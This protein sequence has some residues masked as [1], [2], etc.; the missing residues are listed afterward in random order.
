MGLNTR[1]GASSNKT[2]L[3]V[4]QGNLVL[5]Y[6]K[7]AD[8][9]KKVESLGLDPDKIQVRQRTKGKNEGKDVFYYVLY[10]VSGYLTSITLNE[11]S[12]GEFLELEFTDVDEKFS[13][14]LGD[15]YSRMAKDFIRRVGGL[16]LNEEIVFSVWNITAEEADNGKSKSGVLMYQNDEKVEYFVEFEDLP[17]PEQ[18]KKGRKTIWDFTEQENYLYD[19]LTTYVDENFNDTDVKESLPEKKEKDEAPSRRGRQTRAANTSKQDDDDMPF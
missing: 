7:E 17:E 9:E 3:N 8:L 2:Y 11:N 15:V 4:Y 18:K 1:R 10:D 12:F 6:S 13:V 19:I 14:S 5:E 16:D